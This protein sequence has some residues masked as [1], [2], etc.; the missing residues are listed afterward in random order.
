MNTGKK[1]KIPMGY[2]NKRIKV[3]R[4]SNYCLQRFVDNDLNRYER[5]ALNRLSDKYYFL[6]KEQARSILY[7]RRAK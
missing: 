7:N 4:L 6:A 1:L 2:N 5:S 3:N